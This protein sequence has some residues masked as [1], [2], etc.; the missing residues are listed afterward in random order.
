MYFEKFLDAQT[1]GFRKFL[2]N[3]QK[4]ELLKF[5]A[6]LIFVYQR[7]HKQIQ[8]EF[9]TMPV[10]PQY[11]K[12]V[13]ESLIRLKS[14]SIPGGLELML[15]EQMK[16]EN[17][18]YYFND[19]ELHVEVDDCRKP[20]STDTTRDKII[21]SLLEYLEIRL[22]GENENSLSEMES[23]LNFDKSM[24]ITVFHRLIAKNLDISA[25]YL[26]YMD[27]SSTSNEIKCQ[28]LPD[29]LKYLLKPERIDYFSEIATII[30]RICACTPN[31]ADCERVISANN[32]LK[33]YK[34]ASK[35]I[36]TENDYL[37]ITLTC[38]F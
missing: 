9:L 22:E 13:A 12:N 21:N 15:M 29:S 36:S 14:T 7:F 25:L 10:F 28:P 2:T 19:I 38:Q 37:Y 1:N 30:A 6:D 34:R 20:L 17:D 16:I 32:N 8:S 18:Q 26:L 23:F 33:T 35:L 4:L 11:V 24:D 27:L 5:F 3:V 31:S